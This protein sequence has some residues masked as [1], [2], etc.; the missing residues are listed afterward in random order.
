[1]ETTPRDPT[2]VNAKLNSLCF[3]TKTGS[4]FLN[5]VVLP[6]FNPESRTVFINEM[7]QLRLQVH[8]MPEFVVK[9][10]KQMQ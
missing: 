9:L 7:C 2:A 10:W 8:E 5:A 3:S 6:S 1:M 4:H